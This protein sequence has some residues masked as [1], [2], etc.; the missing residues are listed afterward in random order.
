MLV[1]GMGSLENLLAYFVSMGLV[2]GSR[3]VYSGYGVDGRLR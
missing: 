1:G 3:S 2:G